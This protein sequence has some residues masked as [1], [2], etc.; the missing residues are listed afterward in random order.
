MP[1]HTPT[2]ESSQS[3]PEMMDELTRHEIATWY[4][5]GKL[6]PHG[7]QMAKLLDRALPAE[8]VDKWGFLLTRK[9]I[10]A[11][12]REAEEKKRIAAEKR[13]KTAAIRKIR[14]NARKNGFGPEDELDDFASIHWAFMAARDELKVRGFSLE[15][16]NQLKADVVA[17]ISPWNKRHHVDYIKY[18][19][20]QYY[21]SCSELHVAT[22]PASQQEEARQGWTKILR[23]FKCR[24]PWLSPLRG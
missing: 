15:L 8:K 16:M 11:I 3:I 1:R 4:K 9:E 24:E 2:H 17:R 23:P 12:R 18:F 22:L 14:A 5:D 6:T 7:R 19:I 21:L 13:A 20:Y 10:E